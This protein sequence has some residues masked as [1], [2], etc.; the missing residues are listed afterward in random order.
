MREASPFLVPLNVTRAPL[1]FK[2]T[3]KAKLSNS[4][5]HALLQDKFSKSLI[6]LLHHKIKR[7]APMLAILRRS[8]FE[9]VCPTL[10]CCLLTGR[11]GFCCATN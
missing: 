5:T 3:T 8:T 7:T 2:L 11:T 1:A 4:H 9:T 6:R 10:L